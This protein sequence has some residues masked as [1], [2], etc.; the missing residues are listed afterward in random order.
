MAADEGDECGPGEDE[1]DGGEVPLRAAVL[2]EG[3]RLGEGV[4]V[5]SGQCVGTCVREESG[6]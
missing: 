5:M 6:V 3:G 2:G 4:E 1:G